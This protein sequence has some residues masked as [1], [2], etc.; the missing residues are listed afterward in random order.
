MLDERSKGFGADATG[1]PQCRSLL[2]SRNLSRGSRNVLASFPPS[3]DRFDEG[4][5]QP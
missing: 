5:L 4:R 1:S 3:R 2:G